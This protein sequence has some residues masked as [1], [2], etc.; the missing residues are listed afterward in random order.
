MSLSMDQMSKLLQRDDKRKREYE[1]KTQ[2]WL[3]DIELM[4]V[5]QVWAD[6][7]KRIKIRDKVFNIGYDKKYDEVILRP[8]V[9]YVPYARIER[10]KLERLHGT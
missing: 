4:L 7:K 8:V 2:T 3:D 1:K 10:D 6:G 9:G 5:A